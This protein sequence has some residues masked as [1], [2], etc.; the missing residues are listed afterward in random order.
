M[1][2]FQCGLQASYP[3]LSSLPPFFYTSL[4]LYL[5]MS[6]VYDM[7]AHT[8]LRSRALDFR[9]VK[10]RNIVR[11]ALWMIADPGMVISVPFLLS[12]AL[13]IDKP[14]ELASVLLCYRTAFVDNSYTD[15][16]RRERIAYAES[17]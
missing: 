11:Q 17:E 4:F 9:W 6:A 1:S 7:P 16:G 5:I 13:V 2:T 12:Y 14:G 10:K 15:V 8:D 3:R